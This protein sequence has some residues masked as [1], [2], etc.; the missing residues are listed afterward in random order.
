MVT[1]ST[2]VLFPMCCKKHEAEESPAITWPDRLDTRRPNQRIHIIYAIFTG[3]TY[4][5]MYVFPW[6]NVDILK[7]S[8][9]HYRLNR[10]FYL[11]CPLHKIG[12][13]FL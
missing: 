5:L 6:Q 1:I 3:S 12:R 9:L 13:L 4:G 10:E 7:G 2:N 8:S 11:T